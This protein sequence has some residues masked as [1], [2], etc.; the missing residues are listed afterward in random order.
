VLQQGGVDI[1]RQRP[2]DKDEDPR[3]VAIVI[4]RSLF[5]GTDVVPREGLYLD[6]VQFE[7]NEFDSDARIIEREQARGALG[8]DAFP[9]QRAAD[10]RLV[11]VALR[12][13]LSA[14]RWNQIGQQTPP[15]IGEIEYVSTGVAREQFKERVTEFLTSRISG[16]FAF[17]R[18]AAGLNPGAFLFNMP[19]LFSAASAPVVGFRVDVATTTTQVRIHSSLLVRRNWSYFG[20][21]TGKPVVGGLIG[22]I[23]EFGVDGAA[24]THVHPDSGHFDIPRKTLSPRLML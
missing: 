15:Y 10:G 4:T 24:Y 1:M 2:T 18:S 9:M 21:Y 13:L 16:V 5:E 11:P 19:S 3:E 22:G 12:Y 17:F 7:I 6:D 8:S 14:I 20:F 23:Y